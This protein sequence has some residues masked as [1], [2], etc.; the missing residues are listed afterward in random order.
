MTSSDASGVIHLWNTEQDHNISEPVASL[1]GH[2]ARVSKIAFHPSYKY[3]ASA[4]FDETWR[5]WDL[6]THQEIWMQRHYHDGTGGTT[7]YI[8]FNH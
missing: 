4:S 3:V 8:L 6:E 1:L 2:E 5:L 7:H